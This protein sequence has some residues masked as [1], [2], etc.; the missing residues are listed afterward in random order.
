LSDK[1][2]IESPFSHGHNAPCCLNDGFKGEEIHNDH[3]M[4]IENIRGAVKL[5]F[6]GNRFFVS[7]APVGA[8]A[9]VS[10]DTICHKMHKEHK[11]ETLKT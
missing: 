3:G 5:F 8:K 7:E 1:K 4:N 9:T 10:H 2:L 11:G 6:T